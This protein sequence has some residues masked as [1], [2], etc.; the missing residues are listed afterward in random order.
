MPPFASPSS[1]N[2]PLEKRGEKKDRRVVGMNAGGSNDRALPYRR[3]FFHASS[4]IR[5]VASLGPVKMLLTGLRTY[6]NIGRHLSPLSFI[7]LLTFL[8]RTEAARS[9]R[10]DGT[11]FQTSPLR[12]TT[13][14]TK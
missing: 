3:D 10:A 13:L 4:P 1:D 14:D 2:D 11:S 5:N 8:W 12:P 9:P 7:V 6:I